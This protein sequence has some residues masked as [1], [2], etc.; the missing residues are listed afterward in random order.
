MIMA[1]DYGYDPETTVSRIE[2]S[3]FFQS[4]K[5]TSGKIECD[6]D[7]YIREVEIGRVQINFRDGRLICRPR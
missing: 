1:L 5:R 2:G 3:F 7:V 4:E 6:D